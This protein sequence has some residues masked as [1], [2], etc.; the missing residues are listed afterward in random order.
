M[1]DDTRYTKSYKMGLALPTKLGQILFVASSISIIGT[2]DHS[3][4]P[5]LSIVKYIWTFDVYAM[6]VVLRMLTVIIVTMML[7]MTMIVIVIGVVI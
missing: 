5:C 2:R 4:D 7:G 1:E 3:S 6:I